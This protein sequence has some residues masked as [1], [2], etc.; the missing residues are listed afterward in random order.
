MKYR[1]N[2]HSGTLC[3]ALNLLIDFILDRLL[4]VSLP[5]HIIEYSEQKWKFPKIENDDRLR[6]ILWNDDSIPTVEYWVGH[7]HSN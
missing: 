6:I 3:R 4:H 7:S 2:S 5:F 1:F